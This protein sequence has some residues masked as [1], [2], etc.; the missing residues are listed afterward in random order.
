MLAEINGSL[1]D[2]Y[3]FEFIYETLIVDQFSNMKCLI[4]SSKPA[5][6][7][8]CMQTLNEMTAHV[9]SD[10]CEKQ[11]FFKMCSAL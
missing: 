11:C 10:C 2:N 5:T 8:I 4:G 9:P 7:E 6:N 1:K 3:T